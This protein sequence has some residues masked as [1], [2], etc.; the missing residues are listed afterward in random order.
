MTSDEAVTFLRK[1]L[2]D[3]ERH[4]RFVQMSFRGRLSNEA[5]AEDSQLVDSLCLR[6]QPVIKILLA[7]GLPVTP[8]LDPHH[9]LDS[10]SMAELRS[11]FMV[12]IGAFEHGMVDLEPAPAAPVEPAPT[13][14]ATPR[15]PTAD[16]LACLPVT[17]VLGALFGVRHR[18][19]TLGI[20]VALVGTG[21]AVAFPAGH[22]WGGLVEK[23][24]QELA[25]ERAAADR[26]ACR[27][28]LASLKANGPFQ[29]A[30]VESG[31]RGQ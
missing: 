17:D 22:A 15:Q 14:A 12:A 5:R 16:D 18:W 23:K 28:E 2:D 21:I 7:A 4:A 31:Q 25:V 11:T 19:T 27:A 24:A 9:E 10:E 13:T 29:A 30:G 1:Y 3:Y 8:P 20:I 6:R 26:D